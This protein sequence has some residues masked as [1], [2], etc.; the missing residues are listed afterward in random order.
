MMTFQEARDPPIS[1]VDRDAGMGVFP[2]DCKGN[3]PAAYE[4]F[5][6]VVHLWHPSQD[7]RCHLPLAAWVAK[8]HN[9]GKY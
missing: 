3:R 9:P 2:C 5:G 7:F 1:V 8:Y 4:G 6:V